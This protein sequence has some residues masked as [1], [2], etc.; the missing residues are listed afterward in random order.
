MTTLALT[1]GDNRTITVTASE[2]LDG[3]AIVFT[4]RHRK[5]DVLHVIRK[6]SETDGGIELGDPST[7][8][9]ISL[10]PEDTANLDPCVLRWD[11]E[12]VD[13]DD[14]TRTVASGSLLVK[15]DVSRP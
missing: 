3:S 6:T 12:V 4:A 11:I 7:T 1:R 2:D 5:D 10:E 9:T 13:S 15:G 14:D 8:V